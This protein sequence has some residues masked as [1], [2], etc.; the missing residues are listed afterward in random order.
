MPGVDAIWNQIWPGKVSDYPK[1]ASSAAHLFGRPRAFTES[2]AAYRIRPSVEQAKWVLDYQFVR[3]INMV[4]VMFVPASSGGRLGLSGWNASERFPAV[5]KYVQRVSYLLSQGFPAAQIA[6]YYPTSSIWLG[7][8]KA[9]Q[10]VLRIT[11]HLLESQRDFDFVDEQAISS[12]LMPG[13]GVLKN[14]SG[15]VY[16]TVI[17]PPVRVISKTALDRLRSFA[18]KGGRVIVL[19]TGPSLV[20]DKTFLNAEGPADI[21]WA[22][23]EPSGKLTARV[24]EALPDPDIRL[25]QPDPSVKGIHRRLR[26]AD[27]YFFF[28][29]AAETQSCIVELQG[30]GEAQS[31][32]AMTGTIK[33][34]N[35]EST[36][37]GMVRVNLELKPYETQ[38]IVVGAILPGL[39]SE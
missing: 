33:I 8:M 19:G 35:G 22:V 10:E 21:G 17:I 1:Y 13:D 26:D 11:Q 16:R 31:W 27:L 12:V 3:G 5:A 25:N 14:L 32:N 15:Q 4:E 24:I 30:S 29:E 6:L 37:S 38:T 7:D 36:D 28:N 23:H 18:N 34:M 2:F 39:V 9:D 20:A